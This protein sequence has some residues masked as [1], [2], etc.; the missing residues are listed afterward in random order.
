MNEE[1]IQLFLTIIFSIFMLLFCLTP[2]VYM[3]L[4]SIN[5][6]PDFLA[7]GFNLTLFN[8]KAVLGV[9]SLHFID[10]LKNSLIVSVLSSLI[11]VFISSLAAYSITRLEMKG[12]I[13]ILLT[14][15]AISMFP[16][17]SLIGYLFEL[18][19]GLGLINT[20]VALIF[21]YV[22]WILP[23]S[24]W[25]LV[26]YF[27]QI[28]KELD[29]AAII[30]GCSKFQVLFKVIFPVALPGLF[31]TFLLSFIFAFNEFIF[32]LILTIDHNARTIPVGI[33]L[34]EGLHGE[35]PWGNIMAASTITIIPV[36]ILTLVFQRHII[37]GLTRGAV[38]G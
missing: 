31:S 12:K 23:L 3:F 14:I 35:I 18:I 38:K 4:T 27:S 30:D 5:L 11:T 26:S 8:Y 9:K 2:F 17:I 33:A 37:G 16:Q 36:I 25:I 20:Y 22:A 32:A 1:K 24:L 10:Y 15:L 28:P 29:K 19:S 6:N 21:P 7:T 13:F 34:F